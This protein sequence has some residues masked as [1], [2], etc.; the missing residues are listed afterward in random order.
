MPG[1]ILMLTGGV[2]VDWD[3]KTRTKG[4][5]RIVE[6]GHKGWSRNV[7]TELGNYDFL[8]GVDVRWTCHCCENHIEHAFRLTT[9]TPTSRK[10]S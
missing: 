3:H 5:Y 4:V 10:T 8:L 1:G 9:L 6:P 2:G 7:D